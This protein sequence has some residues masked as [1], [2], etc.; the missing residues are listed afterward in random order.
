[1][2]TV[3]ECISRHSMVLWLDML[4]QSWQRGGYVTKRQGQ[5]AE[6]P[7]HFV[8]IMMFPILKKMYTWP[9][10]AQ[11]T[12]AER[13]SSSAHS[14]TDCEQD[15]WGAL[16][17]RNKFASNDQGGSNKEKHCWQYLRLL[18]GI[19]GHTEAFKC[20]TTNSCCNDQQSWLIHKASV[21]AVWPVGKVERGVIQV[22]GVIL[23]LLWWLKMTRQ[24]EQL[25]SQIFERQDLGKQGRSIC[26]T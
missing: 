5:L 15:F 16:H 23:G 10:I 26:W 14:F 4:E 12:K 22:S 7:S 18:S 24:L 1:M 17:W 21:S 3:L 6:L 11:R 8:S 19:F 2:L 20:H 13:T 25:S 9:K